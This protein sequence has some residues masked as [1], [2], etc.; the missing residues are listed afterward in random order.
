MPYSSIYGLI[1]EIC[2]EST[3]DPPS[4]TIELYTFEKQTRTVRLKDMLLNKNLIIISLARDA[5]AHCLPVLITN[6]ID[7]D[8]IVAIR[9]IKD[10][11][12]GTPTETI[13]GRI[14][15]ISLSHFDLTSDLLPAEI[16]NNALIT[17]QLVTLQG[18]VMEETIIV[19]IDLNGPDKELRAAQLSLIQE[20]YLNNDPISL[21]YRRVNAL[22]LPDREYNSL[23]SLTSRKN[24][25]LQAKLPETGPI[26]IGGRTEAILKPVVK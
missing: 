5:F 24:I 17:L 8:S 21:K 20:C 26:T 14:V 19:L 23:V 13:T 12:E 18:D 7:K 3:T 4:A 16:P 9:I 6:D 15:E 22:S 10:F 1:K 2:I 25:I 11:Y